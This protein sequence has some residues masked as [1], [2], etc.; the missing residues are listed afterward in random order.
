MAP[1]EQRRWQQV[2]WCCANVVDPDPSPIESGDLN[3]DGRVD[4]VVGHA[5]WDEWGYYL[6]D[7]AGALQ[8]EQ[9]KMM[10]MKLKFMHLLSHQVKMVKTVSFNRLKQKKKAGLLGRTPPAR[11]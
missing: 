10:K 11:G 3:G 7:S 5:S 9:I 8:S 4:V 2:P 1:R 6:Q